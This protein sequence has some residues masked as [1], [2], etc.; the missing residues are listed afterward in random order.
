MRRRGRPEEAQHAD[1]GIAGIGL[2]LSPSVN[3]IS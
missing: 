3:V 2:V 1:G